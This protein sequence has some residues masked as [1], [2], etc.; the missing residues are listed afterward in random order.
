VSARRWIAVLVA[1]LASLALRASAQ[2]GPQGVARDGAQGTTYERALAAYRAAEY[3]TARELWLDALEE[4]GEG[5][6]DRAT[7]LY[8]LGN[9]AYRRKRP[10]EAAGWYTASLR[11]APRDED[12]RHNL[13]L[14]R[15]EA[16]LEPAD[17]GDL[18]ATAKRLLTIGTVDECQKAALAIGALLALALAWEALRGGTAAKATSL[19]L[20]ALLAGALAPWTYQV[21]VD[22]RELVF[23]TAPEGADVRSEPRDG[24]ARI[25]R[26]SAATEVERIDAVAGWVRIEQGAVR[27]WIEREA[28]L[29][30]AA[31]YR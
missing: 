28:C 19:A 18:R 12:A 4:T 8:D 2:E 25:A 16:G 3:A 14:V 15:R 5:A 10:L 23:V 6:A 26:V 31:P 29:P 11:L 20:A 30:L 21:L 27:G 17:R 9:V 22:D 24:S 1:A 7:V 13:E